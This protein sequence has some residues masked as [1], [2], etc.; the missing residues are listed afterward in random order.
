MATNSTAL[1]FGRNRGEMTGATG[2]PVRCGVK[3]LVFVSVTT[4]ASVDNH[5]NAGDVVSRTTI[6]SCIDKRLRDCLRIV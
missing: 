6:E 4:A 1:A 2:W 5:N 3:E